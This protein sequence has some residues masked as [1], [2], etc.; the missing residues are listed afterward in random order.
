LVKFDFESK[1]MKLFSN[2]R[3]RGKGARQAWLLLSFML[4]T[5]LVIVGFQG[6]W[7]RDNY[8]REKQ[9]LDIKTN[10]AFRQTILRLQ[11]SK[12]QIDAVSVNYDSSNASVKV[13]NPPPDKPRQPASVM[14]IR[15]R[16][17]DP[18]L[19]INYSRKE[20]TITIANLIQERMREI[21]IPDSISHAFGQ[22]VLSGVKDTLRKVTDSLQKYLKLPLK[23]LIGNLSID[24]NDSIDPSKIKHV[25]LE[26]AGVNK[27]TKNRVTISYSES[28]EMPEET[29]DVTFARTKPMVTASQGS[30]VRVM[31]PTHFRD[32]GRTN[33]FRFLY[34][35]DSL[36]QKD[37]VTIK[38]IDSAFSKRLE[39]EKLNVDFAVSRVNRAKPDSSAV[40]EVSVGFTSPI[41]YRLSV[42]NEMGFLFGKLK[43]PILFSL[44]LVGVTIASFV[45]L[46]R[47]LMKQ[48]RLAQI[49]N[50]L[51]SNITHELKTPIATV[52]VAIEA[53]K[54]FNALQDPQRTREYLDISQNE[55]QRLGLL[56]D[57]VLKLSMFEKKD[58]E[59]KSEYFDLKDVLN[60][61][62][63]S[64]RLQL[65]KYHAKIDIQTEGD[66]ALKGDRLHLLSVVFNLLDN[67]LKYSKENPLL[68]VSLKQVNEDIELVVKDNGI[69]IPSQYKDKVFEKFFRVPA[70]DTHNAK[71]HGLGL[72]YVAQVIR[73]HNGTIKV[74]SREGFGSTF[75]IVL[76]KSIT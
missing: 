5:I 62:V 49:K 11:A 40:N 29:R 16:K 58:I 25:K 44:L 74:D 22:V 2:S 19:T 57:K 59:L 45:A 9:N 8:N 61:V 37:S 32:S 68:E 6:Y 48:H 41:T 38:E 1:K 67:A 4:L 18:D 75:T 56:V 17:S 42:N 72:S 76:P 65:E 52:G 14:R 64:L 7:L 21:D 12:F 63:A 71:G 47:S 55:L 26:R 43:L 15:T 31:G 10:A 53:L 33:V 66:T 70:G 60:E 35:M 69:G 27:A 13:K 73:Q 54:N 20:P 3:E 30:S 28:E 24:E 39:S 36:S 46:Y 51:I 34:D 23:G 50:D